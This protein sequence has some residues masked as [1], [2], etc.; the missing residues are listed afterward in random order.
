MI[1]SLTLRIGEIPPTPTPFP[2]EI[3][4]NTNSISCKI[5][6]TDK[7]PAGYCSNTILGIDIKFHS[8]LSFMRH[9]LDAPCI[10]VASPICLDMASLVYTP[11]T[12]ILNLL[13][14]LSS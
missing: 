12:S 3:Y 6:Y 8:V 14:S 4:Q 5:D 10:L 11:T 1:E 13:P 7:H 9:L 2:P